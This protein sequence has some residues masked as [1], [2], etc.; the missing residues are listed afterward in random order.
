LIDLAPRNLT[1]LSNDGQCE[2]SLSDALLLARAT[3]MHDI[4]RARARYFPQSIMR[5]GA[6]NILLSLFVA[7]CE[8]ISVSEPSLL[9]ANMEGPVSG[10]CLID[11]LVQAGLAQTTGKRPGHRSVGLT[12]LGSARMR[13][14]LADLPVS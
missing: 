4:G 2:T 13:S 8:G 5:D 1:G 6:M 12:P 11:Q 14:Y 7:E 10:G 9:L 3:Q